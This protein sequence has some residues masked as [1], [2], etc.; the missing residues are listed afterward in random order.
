MENKKALT[1][2]CGLDCF[3][4]EIYEEN[5]TDDYVENFQK[6]RR[7]S[8]EIGDNYDY[9]SFVH[10]TMDILTSVQISPDT[11]GKINDWGKK[12]LTPLCQIPFGLGGYHHLLIDNFGWE[13]KSVPKADFSGKKHPM[14]A[15][16]PAY[17]GHACGA[18]YDA[19]KGRV[20]GKRKQITRFI[21][22]LNQ[23][24]LLQEHDLKYLI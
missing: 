11:R 19:E 8:V 20:I 4:C 12:G 10:K 23:E 7:I 16:T 17:F 24:N 21:Q 22:F 2:P 3:N 14:F 9:R 5:L 18:F 13:E 15:I 6:I 1:A